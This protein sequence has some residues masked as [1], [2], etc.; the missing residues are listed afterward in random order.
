MKSRI[1]CII[2]IYILSLYLCFQ[3]A[4]GALRKI[5]TMCPR[6]SDPFYLVNCYI[7]WVTTSWTR[8]KF[9]KSLPILYIYIFIYIYLHKYNITLIV[10]DHKE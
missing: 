8:R 10:I 4:E 3:A 5:R 1:F 7:K 2:Q 9:K 6:S